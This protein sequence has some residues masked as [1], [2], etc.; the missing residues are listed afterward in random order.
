MG[1]D[2]GRRRALLGR[3]DAAL[4]PELPDRRR[5]HAARADRRA[6]DDQEGGGARQPRP[7][8]APRRQGAARSCRPP[9]RSSRG[10]LDDEFPLVVWQTGSGT[11]TNMNVNEVIANRANELAGGT[12]GGKTPVHPND[13]VNLSQ[14]SNDVFPTAMHVAAVGADRARTCCPRSRSC[15]RTLDAKAAGVRR[16]RQDR[17]HAPA[18]RDA[19]HARPG[20]Q[21]LGRAARP[22]HRGDPRRARRGP[23]ARARRHRGRHRA[24]R[25]SRVRGARRGQARRADRP[26]VRHRA[27]QVR[28]AR[29][30]TTRSSRC[31]A[32]SRR[33]RPR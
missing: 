4:A 5:A 10:E 33:W 17:P 7:R 18:G 26:A 16:H 15:A 22:R 28:G 3:A 1:A 13:H 27:E 6:R 19:A 25:A 8:P 14:S 32:R 11:Q 2:R 20:D 12:R 24:Q 23:R 31:T 9:T 30:R 29:R 21:R